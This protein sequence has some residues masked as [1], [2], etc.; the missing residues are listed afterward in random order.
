MNPKSPDE[1]QEEKEEA[2]FLR[3]GEPTEERPSH[4]QHQH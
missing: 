2:E 4:G 3:G 1:L